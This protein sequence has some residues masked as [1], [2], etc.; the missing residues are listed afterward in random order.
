L[1]GVIWSYTAGLPVTVLDHIF[2][3]V[4]RFHV[5]YWKDKPVEAWRSRFSSAAGFDHQNNSRYATR[6][7]NTETHQAQAEAAAGKITGI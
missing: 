1:G 7:R 2:V 3:G 4:G 6:N 5:E